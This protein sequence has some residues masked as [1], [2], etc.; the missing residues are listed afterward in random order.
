MTS[1]QLRLK[2][3]PPRELAALARALA[4]RLGVP[5][6]VNDRLDVALAWVPPEFISAPMTFH[7]V[8]AVP[9]RRDS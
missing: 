9:R 6:L 1:V 8:V 4:T 5:V 3:C 2:H 7:R